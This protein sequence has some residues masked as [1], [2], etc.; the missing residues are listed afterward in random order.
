MTVRR[1]LL[2]LGAFLVAAGG[3]T[4]LDAAGRL[5]HAALVDLLAWWPVA[6]IA[7]GL[8]LVLRRTA[9]AI[10]A[11]VLAAVT[12][13][14]LLGG[15]VVS[16][17]D[18]P[19]PCAID[20]AD[21]T[22]TGAAVTRDGSF[23]ATARVDLELSCG[24]LA[25]RTAPGTAWSV[26]ARNDRNRSADITSDAG[27]L[28]V[29]SQVDRSHVGWN[30]GVDDWKVTLPTGS[31]LDLDAT[32]NAGRGRLDLV[33]ARLGTLA[34]DV[35]AGETTVN[36]ANAELSRLDV[37]VNAGSATIHLP[38]AGGF[39]GDLEANAG[40]LVVCVPAGL[41]LR[42][43]SEAALGSIDINGLTRS[44]DAWVTP[45]TTSAQSSAEL[46]VQASVGSVEINTEGACK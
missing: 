45:G 7:I 34:L 41:A 43:T 30:P 20:G 38:A 12:P 17:P 21:G 36:L 28:D 18:L 25:V 27:R 15:M 4:L 2:Y 22:A 1:G 24:E 39:T 3:V 31:V 23:D 26:D 35:N 9:A 5:D 13:G 37:S 32:V 19:T 46:S 29:T 40:A 8:A 33:G 16:V 14:L 44:G 6:I 10:P 42:V 11:G